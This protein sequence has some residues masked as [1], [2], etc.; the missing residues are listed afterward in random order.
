MAESIELAFSDILAS[1]GAKPSRRRVSPTE[2]LVRGVETEFGLTLPADYRAFLLAHGGTSVEA[3]APFLEPTPVGHRA[4]VAEFFG[5]CDDPDDDIR[6]A[7]EIS[8]GAPAAIPIAEDG[9]FGNRIF[10]LLQGPRAGAVLFHDLQGRA[11]W[12]DAQFT[13][14]FPNLAP[15]IQEYLTLRRQGALPEKVVSGAG[16][17]Y[18]LAS[19]FSDFLRR[20]RRSDGE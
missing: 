2:A 16:D 11:A 1:L 3:E 9:G 5:F 6:G 20:C 15:S 17:F 14:W 19:S 4:G 12:P 7:T 10:L 18:L 13:A 8:D